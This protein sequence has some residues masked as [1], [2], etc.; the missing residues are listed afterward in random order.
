MHRD[1][2][3]SVSRVRAL[4]LKKTE[5][6][7]GY[8]KLA[9]PSRTEQMRRTLAA[10]GV[11][12][13][14]RARR[15]SRAYLEA[16]DESIKLFP[17]AEQVLAALKPRFPLG[18][19]ANGPADMQRMEIATLGIGHYFDHLLIEGELGEGE[20]SPAVFGM[21]RALMGLKPHQVMMVGNSYRHDIEGAMAAGWVGVWIRRPSDAAVGQDQP[22]EKPENAPEPDATIGNLT[23]LLTLLGPGKI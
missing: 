3:G 2:G 16:R 10:L 22:E 12:S 23:E 5:W 20:P 9:E 18:L 17:E 21:A 4:S 7:A 15:L 13:E 8:L 14:E 11:P 6:Y 19:I 1:L